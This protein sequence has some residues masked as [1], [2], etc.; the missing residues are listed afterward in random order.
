MKV[1]EHP[2]KYES[3][4]FVDHIENT[5]HISKFPDYTKNIYGTNGSHHLG[6][7][8]VE[9]SASPVTKEPCLYRLT[10]GIHVHFSSRDSDTGKII[11][12]PIENIVKQ[13]DEVFSKEIE[14]NGRIKGEWEPKTHGFEYRSLPCDV[15]ITKVVKES[16]KILR[17]I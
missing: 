8:P 17:S 16:F 1:E 14:F 9:K 3:K 4:E 6:V 2:F 12:L 7:F 15:D 13:M 11:Q 10:A 5:Y